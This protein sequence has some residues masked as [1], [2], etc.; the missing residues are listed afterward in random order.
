MVLFHTDTQPARSTVDYWT[1]SIKLHILFKSIF[2]LLIKDITNVKKSL[3][4]LALKEMCTEANFKINGQRSSLREK[5]VMR[6]PSKR[7]CNE[8]V[9]AINV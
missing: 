3:T 4:M 8:A 1:H 5:Y 2:R 7:M 9:F 6:P